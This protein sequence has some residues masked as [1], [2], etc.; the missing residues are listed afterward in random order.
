M[1]RTYGFNQPDSKQHPSAWLRWFELAQR[2]DQLGCCS[3]DVRKS[4]G[5]LEPGKLGGCQ[6]LTLGQFV[7][8]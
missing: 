5:G 3:D 2:G 4:F 1:E 8:E 6:P 7:I